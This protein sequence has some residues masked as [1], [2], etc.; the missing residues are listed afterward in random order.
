MGFIELKQDFTKSEFLNVLETNLDKECVVHFNCNCCDDEQVTEINDT[1][2]VIELVNGYYK[3]DEDILFA[4]QLPC[5][6]C[7]CVNTFLKN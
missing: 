7:G 4:M 1:N 5:T 2:D 3:D 6:E